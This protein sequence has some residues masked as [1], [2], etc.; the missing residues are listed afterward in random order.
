MYA[1]RWALLSLC[2]LVAPASHGAGKGGTA[3]TG[4][5]QATEAS[6]DQALAARSK[7]ALGKEPVLRHAT[8]LSVVARKGEVTLSGSVENTAQAERAVQVARGVEGVQRVED[9]L[10]R[11]CAREQAR[12]PCDPPSIDRHR[13]TDR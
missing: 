4:E 6:S 13:C 5:G 9:K 8:N 10:V 7:D 12:C 11:E 3:A 2:L 1:K